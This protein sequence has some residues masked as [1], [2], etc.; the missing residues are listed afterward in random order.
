MNS[1]LLDIKPFHL[2]ALNASEAYLCPVRALAEWINPSEIT[3]GYLFRK[4]A[5]GDRVAEAN[6]PIVSLFNA[7]VHHDY[8]QIC[9]S[10]I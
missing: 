7:H 9:L 8:T 10:D 6:Q 4:F 1:L 2:Y 5:S 3:T